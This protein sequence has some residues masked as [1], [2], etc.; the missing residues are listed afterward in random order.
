MGLQGLRMRNGN[1]SNGN[2]THH[3]SLQHPPERQQHPQDSYQH[4]SHPNPQ[5]CYNP[6]HAVEPL[7]F[8]ALLIPTTVHDHNYIHAHTHMHAHITH[9]HTYT[10]SPAIARGPIQINAVHGFFDG[11]QS[12]VLALHACSTV[13]N[14]RITRGG[15]CNAAG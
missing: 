11:R 5:V 15:C 2:G 9:T 7:S 12:P 3:S 10:T 1:S 4:L 13:C 6:L 14:A 8:L